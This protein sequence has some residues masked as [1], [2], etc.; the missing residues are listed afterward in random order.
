[1][2]FKRSEQ[3]GLELRASWNQLTAC[4]ARNSQTYYVALINTARL[5]WRHAIMQTVCTIFFR[6]LFFSFSLACC[7]S[8]REITSSKVARAIM[9]IAIKLREQQA[10]TPDDFYIKRFISLS[11]ELRVR[12]HLHIIYYL[13]AKA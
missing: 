8:E 7:F 11:C 2:N 1:V 13:F 3:A 12:L 5:Q 9:L 10:A 4:T 6:F